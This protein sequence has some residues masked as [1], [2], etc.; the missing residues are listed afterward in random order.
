MMNKVF[1]FSSWNLDKIKI[2]DPNDTYN[3]E[4]INFFCMWTLRLSLCYITMFSSLPLKEMFF[5]DWR[6]NDS[7]SRLFMLLFF[8]LSDESKHILIAYRD[9]IRL[10]RDKSDFGIEP[11]TTILYKTT[12]DTFQN[13][14]KDV[15]LHTSMTLWMFSRRYLNIHSLK[16]GTTHVRQLMIIYIE[17]FTD[18]VFISQLNS[19]SPRPYISLITMTSLVC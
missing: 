8:L 9:S 7:E 10:G 16:Y 14:E 1:S 18:I 2:I 15:L 5:S 3:D 17:M 4:F 13:E 11:L 6:G 19:C 12:W